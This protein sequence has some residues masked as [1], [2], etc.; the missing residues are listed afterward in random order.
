MRYKSRASYPPHPTIHENNRQVHRPAGC[1]LLSDT[2]HQRPEH[3]RRSS[4]LKLLREAQEVL[5]V[6]LV[7]REQLVLERV[8]VEHA[9]D[10]LGEHVAVVG[11]NRLVPPALEV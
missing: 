3:E 11:V 2:K 8:E 9:G 4:F 1:E 7:T 5:P 6:A 10:R